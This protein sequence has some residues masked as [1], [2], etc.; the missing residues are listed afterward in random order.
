[1]SWYAFTPAGLPKNPC[2]PNSYTLI[3]NTPPSC[4]NPNN[5]LC[6]IQAND[7]LGAPIIT[8]PLQCE[9]AIALQ[10]RTDTVNV[11]LKP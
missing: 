9:I 3:G 8:F 1:M 7:N 11:L 5:F 2:D 4:P 10:N 6:A